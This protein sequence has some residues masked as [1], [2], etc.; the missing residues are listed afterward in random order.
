[1]LKKIRYEN[2]MV[3]YPYPIDYVW[4]NPIIYKVPDVFIPTFIDVIPHYVNVWGFL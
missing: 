4:Y 3:V 1:M 2:E